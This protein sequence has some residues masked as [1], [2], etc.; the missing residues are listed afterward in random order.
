MTIVGGSGLKCF[1]TGVH[2][3]SCS[4]P[5]GHGNSG[6]IFCMIFPY[7]PSPTLFCAERDAK[8]STKVPVVPR[9]QG[10]FAIRMALGLLGRVILCTIVLDE[11]P[12]KVGKPDKVLHVLDRPIFLGLGFLV[13]HPIPS[14]EAVYPRNSTWC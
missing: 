14:P 8:A 7:R 9:S 11:P 3:I 1:S 5:N 10:W 4:S 13:G 6:G 2:V 12:A